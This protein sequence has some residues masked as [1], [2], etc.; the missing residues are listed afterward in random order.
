MKLAEEFVCEIS[1]MLKALSE[2]QRLRI[3]QILQERERCVTDIVELLG[4]SQANVSKHLKVLS[5]VSLVKS[6]REGTTIYYSFFDS[7]IHDLCSAICLGYAKLFNKK[8]SHHLKQA[9]KPRRA[10]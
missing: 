5:S 8:F 3:M 6:R 7:C 2:P 10:L 4:T 1:H 9:K